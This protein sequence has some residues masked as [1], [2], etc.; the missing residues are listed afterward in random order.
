MPGTGKWGMSPWSKAHPRA[1]PIS[2]PGSPC[3]TEQSAQFLSLAFPLAA[4]TATVLSWPSVTQAHVSSQ[5]SVSLAALI[6]RDPGA[7][8][9][10]VEVTMGLG[11]ADTWSAVFSYSCLLWAHRTRQPHWQPA[12]G[13]SFPTI[14]WWAVGSTLDPWARQGQQRSTKTLFGCL[15]RSRLDDFCLRKKCDDSAYWPPVHWAGLTLRLKV[16]LGFQSR[17]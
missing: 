12:P 10:V 2:W 5:I 6:G 3:T 16:L 4:C 7:M 17:S 9:M 13:G 14:P 1:L 11:Q 15:C 8:S